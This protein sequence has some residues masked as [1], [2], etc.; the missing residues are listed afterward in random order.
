MASVGSGSAMTA[1]TATLKAV[2][3]MLAK[4]KLIAASVLE[5]ADADIAYAAGRFQVVGTVSVASEVVNS[6]V[7]REIDDRCGIDICA[8]AG[9][10]LDNAI[11]NAFDARRGA[12]NPNGRSLKP[13]QDRAKNVAP[14]P[15][16][17]CRA[18][19]WPPVRRGGATGVPSSR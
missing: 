15:C 18:G 3:T 16:P 14:N 17:G 6:P 19:S 2:E 12:L 1:G 13:R 10:L 8:V 5:A 9:F 4:G 11:W 7:L